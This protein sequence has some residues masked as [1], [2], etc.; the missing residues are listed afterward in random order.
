M[1]VVGRRFVLLRLSACIRSILS[2][3]IELRYGE[4]PGW[5][6]VSGPVKGPPVDIKPLPGWFGPKSGAWISPEKNPGNT[7]T[8]KYIWEYRFCACGRT[9]TGGPPVVELQYAGD[10]AAE[11]LLN[12][13]VIGSCSTVTTLCKASG[14]PSTETTYSKSLLKTQSLQQRF[15]RRFK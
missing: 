14:I 8:D 2:R 3:G 4:I 5:L 15:T 9:A 7:P 6:L 11:A 1:S 10:S 12:G 13:K